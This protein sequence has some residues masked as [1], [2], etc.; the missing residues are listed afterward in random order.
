MSMAAM[1]DL[2]YLGKR[3]CKKY[4]FVPSIYWNI[5][6][7]AIALC[8]FWTHSFYFVGLTVQEW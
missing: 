7:I 4:V 2:L 3:F 6:H 1:M 5:L 8:L